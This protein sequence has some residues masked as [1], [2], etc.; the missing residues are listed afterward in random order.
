M[1]LYEDN[2]K[3]LL[4]EKEHMFGD[5]GESTVVFEKALS[6]KNDGSVKKVIG[7]CL[8]FSEQ[9]GIIGVE[10]KTEY[11]NVRR[12]L[13]QLRS[14]ALTCDYVYVA[15]HDDH[16]DKVES[17]ITR[18]YMHYVGIIA[19]TEFKGEPIAGIY[20]EAN[21]S[22]K[23][24][25]FHALNML[26]KA[27]IIKILSLWRNPLPEIAQDLGL[28]YLTTDSS[29]GTFGYNSYTY[30]MKKGQLIHELIRKL[31]E[32]EANRVLCRVFINNRLDIKRTV[33]TYHFMSN[34]REEEFDG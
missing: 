12:L 6:H 4:L 24:E 8:I 17:I 31:G 16:V 11:D 9:K 33:K 28:S 29:A 19:Y 20:R 18:N 5:L 21:Y 7:D 30:R 26:W 13:R 27:E 34:P 2:I 14:Y 32:Y 22:P 25:V 10:I 15:C 23:K 1:K 3:Q